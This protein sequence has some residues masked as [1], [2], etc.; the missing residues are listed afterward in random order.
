VI[1]ASWLLFQF[2]RQL[3]LLFHIFSSFVIFLSVTEAKT[4]WREHSER[5]FCRSLCLSPWHDS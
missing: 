2:V 3:I 4:H 5:N 1:K